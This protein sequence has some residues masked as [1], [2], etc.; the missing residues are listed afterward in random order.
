MG[1]RDLF[2]DK[3]KPTSR[4]PYRKPTQ[5]ELDRRETRKE[6]QEAREKFRELIKDNPNAEREW[7][8]KQMGVDLKP[9]DPMET[10]KKEIEATLT[11]EAFKEISDDPELRKRAAEK[12]VEQIVGVISKG[13]EEGGEYEGSPIDQALELVEG[14]E[15]LKERFGVK[16]GPLGGLINAEF[17]TELA[18]QLPTIASFLQGKQ[19][20][21]QPTTYVVEVDGQMMEMDAVGYKQLLEQRELKR[22]E[23]GKAPKEARP[24]E[25]PEIK[26]E[27]GEAEPEIKLEEQPE[28]LKIEEL[29]P[30]LGLDLTLL[31]DYLDE[32]P[33][34][35]IDGLVELQQNDSPEAIFI[36]NLMSEKEADMIIEMLQ[37]LKAN[38]AYK[39]IVEKL[40]QKQRDEQWLQIAIEYYRSFGEE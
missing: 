21:I 9:P 34:S 30:E 13:E 25:A 22:L 16:A 29:K 6:K 37:P 32:E 40:E 12:I 36:L 20:P 10:R 17:L 7:V 31:A 27:L 8:S 26:P 2:G 28:E 15:E 14:Y 39:G 11:E 33:I 3:K 1:L 24:K 38:E 23:A 5:D 35:F 4:K 19:P 18:K